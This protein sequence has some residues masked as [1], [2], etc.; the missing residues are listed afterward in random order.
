[1]SVKVYSFLYTAWLYPIVVNWLWG[2]GWFV[3]DRRFFDYAGG[4]VWAWT[5]AIAGAVGLIFIP[6]RFNRWNR[7]VD[8]YDEGMEI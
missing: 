8:V 7:Y 1:L 5:G 2:A 3:S 4:T 6:V